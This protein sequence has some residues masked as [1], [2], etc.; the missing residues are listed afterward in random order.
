MN[1]RML[2]LSNWE[3]HGCFIDAK[4]NLEPI[5]N[6]SWSRLDSKIPTH[7]LCFIDKHIYFVHNHSD[8]AALKKSNTPC[9]QW[10]DWYTMIGV[11]FD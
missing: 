2:T 1:F 7:V 10:I 4:T 11:I 6:H 5:W 9:A 8:H 3:I